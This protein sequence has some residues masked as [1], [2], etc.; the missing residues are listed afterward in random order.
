MIPCRLRFRRAIVLLLF[1]AVV[2]SPVPAQEPVRLTLD[3]CVRRA[4]AQ[5]PR[6]A[7]ARSDIAVRQALLDQ[8]NAARY[9][10]QLDL[11]FLAGPAPGAKGSPND[12]NVRNDFG[13]MGPFGRAEMTLLQPLYTF[14]KIDGKADAA[15]HAIEAARQAQQQAAHEVRRETGRLYYGLL[16]ARELKALASD[17]LEKIA[18]ARTKVQESLE[19]GAGQYTHID[20]YRLD[21]VSGEVE[22]RLIA[23][24]ATEPALLAG[25]KAAT[26]FSAGAD[27]DIAETSLEVP[28]RE[29]VEAG[30]AATDAIAARPE[31]RQLRAGDLALAGLVRSARADL[32]PQLFAG[33]LLRYGFAPNRTNQKNPFVRDDFNFLQGG[34][35][36]GFRYSFNFAA[37]QA[38]VRE[39]EGERA[40]LAAQ[41]RAAQTAIEVQARN[42]VQALE[43]ARLRTDARRKSA[44]VGRRWLAA[45]DS[46]FN[47]GVGETRD[48]V[49]AF[50]AYLQ[51]RVALLEAIHDENAAQ[52]ELDY[53]RGSR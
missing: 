38:K 52:A 27:F 15:R 34:V 25:L 35:A 48:L 19:S 22:A 10:P 29:A 16:L 44:S 45:A 47:L 41:Q 5:H 3:E 31:M 32:F 23:I 20:E 13:D 43:A 28:P 1:A 7:V 30:A 21:V 51:G 9:R 17:A 4:L 12:L 37:T 39:V 50:Q 26:G 14:G 2:R 46:N 11:T 36:L 40:R 24:S 33:G 53:A 49:D 42:A 8:A 6:I 18:R